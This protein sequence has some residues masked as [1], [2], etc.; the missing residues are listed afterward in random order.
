V[1][2]NST[3]DPGAA[4]PPGE[5]VLFVGRLDQEKGILLLLDAW[6][7][8]APGTAHLTVVGDGRYRPDVERLAASRA[9]VTYLGAVTSEE[10]GAAIEAA[11]VVVVPS[12]CYEGFGRV[13]VEAFARGRPVL[14][15]D[16]G[17]LPALVPPSCGWT[18]PPDP[19]ALAAA[20]TAAVSSPDLA[21]LGAAARA[22]YLAEFTPERTLA[23]LLDVYAAV[24][25]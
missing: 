22:R 18:V 8:V 6:A 9:D 19:A 2:P 14:A 16:L 21:A 20:L 10:V 4:T 7:R 17:P 13:V 11:A 5:G 15:T 3:P 23:Q 1:R 12:V 24:A 25:R